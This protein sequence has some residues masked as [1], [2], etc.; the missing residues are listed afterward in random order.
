MGKKAQAP[1]ARGGSVADLFRQ[2]VES[3]RSEIEGAKLSRRT[4]KDLLARLDTDLTRESFNIFVGTK[5]EFAGIT[6]G[7][8]SALFRRENLRFRTEVAAD[9][10]GRAGLLFRGSR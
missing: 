10:P 8:S 1:T 6:A 5:K 7:G 3:F 9:R 4:R 2:D